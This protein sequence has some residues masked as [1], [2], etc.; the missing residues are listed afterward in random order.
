MHDVRVWARF[1]NQALLARLCACVPSM[2]VC[3]CA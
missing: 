2:P 3:L 1:I